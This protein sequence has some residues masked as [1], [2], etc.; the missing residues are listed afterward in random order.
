MPALNDWIFPAFTDHE[1]YD[2]TMAKLSDL[3]IYTGSKCNRQC[4]FCIVSGRPDGWY[5]PITEATLN[6]TLAMVPSDGTIKFYGG[7][8]TVAPD[9]LLWAMRRLRELGFRGWL[10]IFSNGVLADRLIKLLEADDRT[11]AVLNYSILHGEDAEPIPADSLAKLQ[12]FA[13]AHPNRIYSSHAGVFPFGRGVDFVA[14][15]GPSHIN[16]RM[17]TS[18]AKKVA[19][20][21]LDQDTATQAAEHGFR[22]CPRCRPVVGTDN[23]HHACPFAVESPMPHFDL[24]AVTDPSEQVLARYQQFLDWI[25]NVLE[26][27]AEARQI[28]PCLVCTNSL[29]TLPKPYQKQQLNEECAN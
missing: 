20:G 25:N 13:A 22:L 15:V 23:R 5:E 6:A 2:R 28:H 27:A 4:D 16:D 11:D 3:H 1:P 9:N 26:P 12:A 29:D 10:T 21:E 19:I 14:E 24:G 8:P 18:L 7:E 17:Q